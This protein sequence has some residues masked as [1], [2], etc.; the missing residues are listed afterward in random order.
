MD[1]THEPSAVRL[2]I[3]RLT[4]WGFIKELVQGIG[5]TLGMTI[6]WVLEVFRNAYFRMLDRLNVK[7]RRRKRASAFPPGR[8]RRHRRPHAA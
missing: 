8:P 1:A 4:T 5:L 2:E 7:P 3:E 6:L